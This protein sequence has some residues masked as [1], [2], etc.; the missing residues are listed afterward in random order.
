MQ[1]ILDTQN[2]FSCPVYSIEKPEWVAKI[3]KAC[4]KH[5]KAAYKREKPKLDKRKKELG[6][7]HW[8]AIKDHGMSYHSSGIETDPA[9]KEF[10]DYC[11][12]TA[13]NLLDGQGFKMSDYQMFFTE[14]WVQEFSK[15]GG[16]HHNAHIHSDNHISGFYYLKCSK[17]TSLPIFHDPRPGA[18]M[19]GLKQKDKLKIS[20][21][22]DQV[23][24][25]PK[26]GTLIFFNSYMPHQYS[27]HD[28]YDDFRFIHFNI[29]AVRNEIVQGAKDNA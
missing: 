20:Y 19:T 11:G 29:Q 9:L 8:N 27:V 2:Y 12:Q 24:Y 17:N 14:C 1:D 18:L 13:W 3:D 10:V 21:A 7:K 23:H 15:H 26:P 5:I 16:G 28:G 6:T 4:D 22:S 25:I